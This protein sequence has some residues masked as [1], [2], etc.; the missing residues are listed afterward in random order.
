MR[1]SYEEKRMEED[2]REGEKMPTSTIDCLSKF[3]C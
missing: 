2:K 1:K 3:M